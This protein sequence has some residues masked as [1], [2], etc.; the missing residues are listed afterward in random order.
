MRDV[1]QRG[2]PVGVQRDGGAREVRGVP[3]R[4]FLGGQDVQELL[5]CPLLDP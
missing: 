5:P 2:E 4:A 3:P 1:R